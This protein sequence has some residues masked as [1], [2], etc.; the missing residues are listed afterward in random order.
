MELLQKDN[1]LDI[2]ELF[3]SK[4]TKLEAIFLFGNY[5]SDSSIVSEQDIDKVLIIGQ[6]LLTYLKRNPF[7][8][9]ENKDTIENLF[10]DQDDDVDLNCH[11]NFCF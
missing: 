3:F 1:A 11:P 10:Y 8:N 2:F 5:Y 9:L 4:L 7:P 6:Q